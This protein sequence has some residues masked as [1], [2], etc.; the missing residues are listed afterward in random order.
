MKL[1]VIGKDEHRQQWTETNTP[2]DVSINWLDSCEV[3][4]QTDYC[5]DL[6]FSFSRERITKLQTFN[7]GLI[8]INEVTACLH[9]LPANF[10]R[11][12]G[13][14]GFS[15][16]ALVEASGPQH[17]QEKVEKLFSFF[18][19]S[20]EWV[21]DIPGLITPRVVSM[22]INEAYFA[23]EDEV[24]TKNEIDTAMKLGTNYPYG[25]FEWATMIGVRKIYELLDTLSRGSERYQPASLLKQEAETR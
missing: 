9:E 21:P 11:F 7:A 19:K 12:N 22:I 23:L 25:P 14:P 13:W 18:G 16:G 2:A 3:A 17:L 1:V 15:N 10:V 4:E 8:I 24:S 20:T 5:I 6:L